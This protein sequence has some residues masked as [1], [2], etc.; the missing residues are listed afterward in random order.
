MKLSIQELIDAA[1]A[2]E[3]NSTA[4][5]NAVGLLRCHDGSDKI[6]NSLREKGT[7]KHEQAKRFEARYMA[8]L[9]AL[10]DEVESLREQFA[11]MAWQDKPSSSGLYLWIPHDDM[12][13]PDGQIACVWFSEGRNVFMACIKKPERRVE[14]Y[15]YFGGLWLKL[16]DAPSGK[17]PM[18]SRHS[19]ADARMYKKP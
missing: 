12:P 4:L 14:K 13:I 7:R 11:P 9:K 8:R 3:S 16:P 2:A 19:Q 6:I 17:P 18:T 1:K 15:E 5:F 10:E